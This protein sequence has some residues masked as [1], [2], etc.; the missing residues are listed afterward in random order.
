MRAKPCWKIFVRSVHPWQQLFRHEV[1]KAGPA[2]AFGA[3]WVVR[4]PLLVHYHRIPTLPFRDAVEAFSLLNMRRLHSPEEMDPYAV[5]LEPLLGNPDIRLSNRLQVLVSTRGWKRLKDLRTEYHLHSVHSHHVSAVIQALPNAWQTIL[6]QHDFQEPEWSVITSSQEKQVLLKG[7]QTEDPY[8]EALPTGAMIPYSGEQNLAVA[9][10]QRVLEP[11]LLGIW[12]EMDLDPR[13]WG[14]SREHHEDSETNAPES[15]EDRQQVTGAGQGNVGCVDINLVDMTV[16]ETRKALTHQATKRRSHNA[17]SRLTGLTEL[18]ALWPALWSVNPLQHTPPPTASE[19]QL[20]LYGLEG[21]EERWKQ[22]L[23]D[24]HFPPEELDQLP[25]WMRPGASSRRNQHASPSTAPLAARKEAKDVWHRLLD[26]TLHRP[27]AIT[28]WHLNHGVLGCNAFLWH[29]GGRL[30]TPGPPNCS[31]LWAPN[32]N[33]CEKIV[34]MT[35]LSSIELEP[36]DDNWPIWSTRM[37]FALDRKGL[38]DV[39]TAEQITE[40]NAEKDRKAKALIG[41]YVKDYLLFNVKRAA[42]AREAW[43]ALKELY[44]QRSVARKQ[45]LRIKLTNLRM[46]P[47]E[48]MARY[49]GRA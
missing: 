10:R 44:V 33:L 40:E 25:A 46:L 21:L 31:R 38:W 34:I 35:K 43:E 4:N 22:P 8:W 15:A 26:P 17:H 5:L 27:F 42:S 23:G 32:A 41:Q 14:F 28:C 6:T 49:V 19:S 7:P 2:E 24:D 20:R 13:G 16:S 39:I 29:I 30:Q 9:D 45:E 47:E 1:S 11:R 36:L 18:G 48:D 12:D 37:E 3:D